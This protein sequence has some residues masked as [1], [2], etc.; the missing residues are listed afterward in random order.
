MPKMVLSARTRAL[1]PTT[2]PMVRLADVGQIPNRLASD[3]LLAAAMIARQV[4]QT[5]VPLSQ[6]STPAAVQAATLPAEAS[7][8]PVSEMRASVHRQAPRTLVLPSSRRAADSETRL[9]EN[10]AAQ[11]LALRTRQIRATV[12]LKLPAGLPRPDSDSLRHSQPNRRKVLATQDSGRRRNQLQIPLRPPLRS[13]MRPD[14]ETQD[15]EL[16][17]LP[18]RLP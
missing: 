15:S 5:P 16:Q 13:G 3:V 6:V 4:L 7:L 1:S 8:M 2:N 14:S 12:H 18:I 11:I 9:R 10:S 17:L